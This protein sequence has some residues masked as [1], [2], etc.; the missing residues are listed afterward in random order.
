L[1]RLPKEEFDRR[2]QLI[3]VDRQAAVEARPGDFEALVME[4]QRTL[5]IQGHVSILGRSLTWSPAAQ[6]PSGRHL[7]VSVTIGEGRTAIHIEEKLELAGF[8]QAVPGFS[9]GAGGLLMMA[10]LSVVFGQPNPGFLPPTAAAAVASAFLAVR[11]M[12]VGTAYRRL[13]QLRLLADRLLAAI[14]RRAKLP[15]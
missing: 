14:T 15:P 13:P 11:S 5:G 4:I 6:G 9:A 3:K 7:L 12:L 8:K 2:A 1:G 10:F